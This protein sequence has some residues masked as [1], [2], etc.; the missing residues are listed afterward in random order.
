MTKLEFEWIHRRND[1]AVIFIYWYMILSER[2]KPYSFIFLINKL[3]LD[4]LFTHVYGDPYYA[5]FPYKGAPHRY[6]DFMTSLN[7]F[8]VSTIK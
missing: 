5:I 6:A 3:V 7:I 4:R 8:L 2:K 1:L